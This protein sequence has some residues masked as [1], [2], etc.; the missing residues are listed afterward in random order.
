MYCIILLIVWTRNEC[1]KLFNEGMWLLK[2]VFIGGIFIGFMYVDYSFFN[3]YR[4]FARIFGALFLVI[5]SVMLIDIFYVWGESWKAKYDAGAA[6]MSSVLLFTAIILYGLTLTLI[7][8]NFVWFNGCGL[9]TFLNIA[10]LVI[11]IAFT[12]VQLLGYNPNGSLI[13]SGAQALYMT[14]LIFSAQLS[15]DSSCNEALT[16]YDNIFTMELV[17]GLILLFVV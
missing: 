14:F 8:L 15:G 7:I 3:G 10:N 13:T 5:Q 9:N 16:N 6:W 17:V 12:V 4:D 11:I 1:S 2:I